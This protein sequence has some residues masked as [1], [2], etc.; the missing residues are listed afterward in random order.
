[1]ILEE[2]ALRSFR[3]FQTFRCALDPQCT[4]LLAPNSSGKT[5]LLEAV[6]FALTGQGFRESREI[7]LINYTGARDAYVEIRVH[8]EEGSAAYKIA[9]VAADTT[10]KK[11]FFVNGSKVSYPQY[12]REQTRAVLF[13]PSQIEILTG[14][15]EKRRSYFN[16]VLSLHDPEYKKR[17]LNYETALRKR[18]K[19]LE[20]E[21]SEST[22]TAQLAFWDSYLFEQAE[23]ISDKRS[24]YDSFVNSDPSGVG[25]P[26]TLLYHQNAFSWDRLEKYREL[27]RR[28]RKTVIGPQ[29]DDYEVRLGADEKNVAL[30]GSRSEQRLA[31]L[32]LKLREIQY[33]IDRTGLKP[34]LLLD[35]IF[36]EFDTHNKKTVLA[37]IR[38]YQT[39]ATTTEEDIVHLA[40]IPHSV[41]RVKKAL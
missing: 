31:I 6:Y 25:K 36:S 38:E 22:I 26:F 39:I 13:A 15:P 18:N 34:I 9:L 37:L 8:T 10:V 24:S 21:Q 32:W 19:V 23:Y 1:M 14:A 33:C 28:I 7:E 35:D 20:S 30:F 4:I 17:L 5:N 16:T 29:K 41:V 40:K 11:A 2:I 12:M 27:E 3:N